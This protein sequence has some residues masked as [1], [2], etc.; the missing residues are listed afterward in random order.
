[1]TE[2]WVTGLGFVTSIGISK[3]SVLDSLINSKA[4]NFLP[5]YAPVPES[6]VKVAGTIKEFDLESSRS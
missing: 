2:V 3:A 1:M 6:P 4:W 5:T